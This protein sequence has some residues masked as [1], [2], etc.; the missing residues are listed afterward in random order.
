MKR[1]LRV[2]ARRLPP[3][4]S[5]VGSDGPIPGWSLGK[6]KGLAASTSA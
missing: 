6:R 4:P 1:L 3:G 2:C 5:P